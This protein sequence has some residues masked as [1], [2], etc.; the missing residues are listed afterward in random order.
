MLPHFK[1]KTTF[2]LT[3]FSF[4]HAQN[5][6]LQFPPLSISIYNGV[7]YGLDLIGKSKG[8]GA[9]Q[10]SK[11]SDNSEVFK[12]YHRLYVKEK[13]TID[14]FHDD[15]SI[16]DT[17]IILGGKGATVSFWAPVSNA[18]C[19]VRIHSLVVEAAETIARF[20]PSIYSINFFYFDDIII[21]DNCDLDISRFPTYPNGG[22]FV[23]KTS[24]HLADALEKILFNNKKG[25]FGVRDYNREYWAI[26]VGS[27]FHPL[28]TPEPATYGAAVSLSGL[29][30]VV[31]RKR[32]RR[33]AGER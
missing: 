31:W 23:K 12:K 30:L 33:W 16:I 8:S 10:E 21:N 2:L 11:L 32:R 20:A 17:D 27:I 22:L 15:L 18:S 6:A 4:L 5:C 25:Q 29:G 14:I 28:P 3:Y 26:G 19:V 24:P 13:E 9:N 7:G 1:F